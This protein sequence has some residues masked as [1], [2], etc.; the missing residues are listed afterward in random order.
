MGLLMFILTSSYGVQVNSICMFIA[1][2]FNA[3]PDILLCKFF[4]SKLCHSVPL[5]VIRMLKDS[6][7]FCGICH[8]VLGI[9]AVGRVVVCR[10]DIPTNYLEKESVCTS[11]AFYQR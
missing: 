5:K 3:G 11:S 6:Q 4:T 1:G 2:A 10:V 8:P 7:D 9:Q